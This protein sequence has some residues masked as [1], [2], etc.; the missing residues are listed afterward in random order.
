M[1]VVHGIV[2]V[3]GQSLVV[4]VSVYE[5]CSATPLLRKARI[6]VGM[7]KE[8]LIQELNGDIEKE[9]AATIQYVQ[10]ASMISRCR[11]TA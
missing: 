4:I 7:T 1:I 10:H 2:P 5:S 3:A 6:T 11:M 8:E 9:Y